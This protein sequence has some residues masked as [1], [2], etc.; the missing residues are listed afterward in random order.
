M[1]QRC[2]Q[3]PALIIFHT[4]PPKPLFTRLAGNHKQLVHK[5]AHR[6]CGQTLWLADG[7]AHL[8]TKKCNKNKELD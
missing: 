8:S 1:N 4:K 5:H 2:T 6:D 3:N 7:S